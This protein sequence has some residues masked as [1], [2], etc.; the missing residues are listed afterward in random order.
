MKK[1][2]RYSYHIS[3]LQVITWLLS[4]P[5]GLKLNEPLNTALASFFRYHI[6]LWHSESLRISF[7]IN[8]AMLF[9]LHNNQY[10]LA[11]SFRT[12]TSSM[13]VVEGVAGCSLHGPLHIS[14]DHR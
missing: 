8:I 11:F 4:N 12:I 7:K 9:D 13:V 14:L 10:Y 6:Y 5:V 1:Q 2:I 3:F